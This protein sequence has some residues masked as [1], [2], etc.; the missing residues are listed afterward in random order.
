MQAA[1]D[2]DRIA[3]AGLLHEVVPL[4]QRT[5]SARQRFLQPTDREDLIQ[6]VLLSL[7]AARDTYDRDDHLFLG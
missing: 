2:G 5:L 4:L 7:H 3:Y 6:D 1:Q